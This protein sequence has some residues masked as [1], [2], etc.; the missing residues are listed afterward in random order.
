MYEYYKDM[1]A[2]ADRIGAVKHSELY[3][4]DEFWGNRSKVSG[5]TADGSEFWM[6]LTIKAKEA[7]HE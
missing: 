7:D 5:I 1:L 3:T 2:I 6:E 4:N